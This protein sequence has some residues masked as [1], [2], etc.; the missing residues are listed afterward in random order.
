MSIRIIAGAALLFFLPLA[1]VTVADASEPATPPAPRASASLELAADDFHIAPLFRAGMEAVTAAQRTPGPEA[2]E[3]LLDEAITNFH[4]ILVRRP[5]LVRVH[6]EI[7]R[8]FYL[9]REDGL[10]R[11]HF[12]QVLAGKPP[13]QVAANIQRFLDRIRAR[14]RWQAWFG[15]GIA[16]DSNLNTASENRTI[17][18]DTPFG[19]FP[20]LRDE[21]STPKSGYGLALWGGGEY[22]HP[23]RERLRLRAGANVSAREHRQST[24]DRHFASVHIGPQWLVDRRTELSLLGTAQRNWTQ[25]QPETDQIGFRVEAERRVT[26]RIR[27]FGRGGLRHRNCRECDWL[28][29]PVGDVSLNANWIAKPILRLGAG[30]GYSW[31]DTEDETRSSKGPRA[32]VTANLALPFGFTFGARASMQWTDYDDE[33]SAGRFFTLDRMPREDRLRV[34]S[35][36]VFNRAFTLYGFSPRVTVINEQRETNAQGLEY[37]RTRA[38]VSFVRQF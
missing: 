18:L 20:F 37:D 38:E 29:G 36:S 23:L 15:L 10:S 28:D 16:Q 33:R 4:A 3:A 12:E 2:R 9:K 35:G 26:P 32:N 21:E 30:A 19:R 17:W 34:L 31:S 25:G 14:R 8:A 22:E 7:A 1:M 24:F 5:D 6:L 11:K 13:A 27:L